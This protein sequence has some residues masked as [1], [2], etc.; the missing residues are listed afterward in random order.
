MLD[1]TFD[2]RFDP[3]SNLKGDSV[4]ASWRFLLP[5]LALDRVVVLGA[6]SDATLRALRQTARE[7]IVVTDARQGARGSAD[8][9]VL[10]DGRTA[11]ADAG[12]LVRPGGIVFS[13]RRRSFGGQADDPELF[14]V[15]PPSGEID[16]AAPLA[17]RPAVDFLSEHARHD[18]GV[19][20]TRAQRIA[21]VLRRNA[22]GARLRPRVATL[23]GRPAGPPAYLCD[24][25]ATAGLDI[26]GWR[27]A[28][29]A[30]GTYGSK[31][32][33][34]FLSDPSVARPSIV[35]KLTRE[36]I[37]NQRLENEAQALET[38]E[39]RG[40]GQGTV[41]RAVFI[42]EHAGLAVVGESAVH[43]VPFRLQSSGRA[44]CQWFEAAMSWLLSLS[45][46]TVDRHGADPVAVA[47][48]L[49]SLLDKYLE[50]YGPP[51]EHHMFLASQIDEIRRSDEPFPLVFQHGDPGT[52]NALALPDGR[53]AFLDWEAAEKEGMPLWDLFYFV[54]SYAVS[55]GPRRRADVIFLKDKGLAHALS[56]A[57]D[58]H[59]AATGLRR[60]L[61]GP[62]FYTCLM[63]RAL[64][65]A[66][67]LRSD[68]LVRGHYATLLGQCIDRRDNELLSSMLTP[69]DAGS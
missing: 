11:G 69:D 56:L 65:E 63:H 57:I 16:A 10:G 44:D 22:L 30:P 1:T 35:V 42:G 50:V 14:W 21:R 59:V 60:T 8:L 55:T 7:V 51:D 29:S 25:A 52:W 49:E 5:S 28:L 9:L 40:F 37:F 4:G 61:A 24:I 54:R 3:A 15:A 38:L 47:S 46:A 58:K 17:D 32:V 2:T 62:L 39:T 68:R 67:R 53:V 31:K 64:K 12:R 6:T 48:V 19:R 26:A 27:Y 66:T 33:L 34:V 41:P 20:R 13:E 23:A 36:S 18:S 43:G 45:A